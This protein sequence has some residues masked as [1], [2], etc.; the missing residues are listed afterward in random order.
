MKKDWNGL[1]KILSFQ[2]IRNGEVIHEEKNIHNMFHIEG[3][4]FM[5]KACF[6]TSG[7]TPPISYYFGLDSRVTPNL[8]DT[9]GSL[10]SQEPI[11]NGY[12][13]SAVSSTGS[14]TNYFTI[15]EVEGVYRATVSLLT[16]SATLAGYGPVRNVFLATSSDNSGTLIA[17]NSLSSPVTL[18][19]G[20]SINIKMSLS[21]QDGG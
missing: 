12:V 1:C 2:H 17:T 19:S 13:R 16:F 5:L 18:S 3:E 6:S 8:S 15:E 10:T 7:N 20:D 21:L 11:G 4:S 14:G 9:I